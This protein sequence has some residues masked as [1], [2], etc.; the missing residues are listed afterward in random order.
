M[1]HLD[2]SALLP[3]GARFFWASKCCHPERTREGSGPAD[4]RQIL[5]E[6]A[7]DDNRAD[8]G[9][10]RLQRRHGLS[11]Q[12]ATMAAAMT[13]DAGGHSSQPSS[14]GAAPG[15]R[16]VIPVEPIPVEPIPV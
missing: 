6:Y 3:R 11:T 16:Q 14:P 1:R 12:I 15:A 2:E 9:G 4:R 10:A 13:Q 5:R 7:Q 8:R